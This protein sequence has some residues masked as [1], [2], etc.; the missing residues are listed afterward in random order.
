MKRNKHCRDL[1]NASQQLALYRMYAG[2]V[3]TKMLPIKSCRDVMRGNMDITYLSNS[4]VEITR[5]TGEA[6]TTAVSGSE[7]VLNIRK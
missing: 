5:N 6:G 1:I 2:H 4:S 7:N 3:F